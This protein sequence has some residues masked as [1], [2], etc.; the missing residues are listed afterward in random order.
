MLIRLKDITVHSKCGRQFSICYL[1]QYIPDD[2]YE[3]WLESDR[4]SSLVN[5]SDEPVVFEY[6]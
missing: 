4:F 1:L 5:Q 6:Q 2:T 3:V